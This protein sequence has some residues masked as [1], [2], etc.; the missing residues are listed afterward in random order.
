[1]PNQVEEMRTF[2]SR[3]LVQ[4]VVL[5]LGV[6]IGLPAQAQTFNGVEIPRN[7]LGVVLNHCEHIIAHE[8]AEAS[9]A[10]TVTESNFVIG[11]TGAENLSIDLDQVGVAACREIMAEAG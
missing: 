4:T 3:L 2:T 8:V 6:A 9:A 7:E 1:V 11:E 10:D 5:A